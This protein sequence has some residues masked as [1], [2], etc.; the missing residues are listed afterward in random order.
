MAG[1]FELNMAELIDIS[2]SV[3][4]Q[5]CKPLAEATA[6]RAR[7]DAAT[8]AVS[9]DYAASIGVW[10]E[11]RTGIKSWARSVVGA[12]IGYGMQ[13]ESRHGTLAKALGQ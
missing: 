5:V 11:P 6:E 3:N 2:N 10:V 1:T 4:E 7:A 12:R 9:G 13:V 8:F